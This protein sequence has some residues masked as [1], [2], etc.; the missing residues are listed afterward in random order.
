MTRPEPMD[1]YSEEGNEY[2][3]SVKK[4]IEDQKCWIKVPA[5]SCK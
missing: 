5:D 4:L 3:K 2:G 1:V